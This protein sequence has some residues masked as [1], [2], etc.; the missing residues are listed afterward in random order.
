MANTV[1]VTAGTVFLV[2]LSW[3]ASGP[4]WSG[5]GGAWLDG[6]TANWNTVGGEIPQAPRHDGERF[7]GCEQVLRPATLPEDARVTAAG[8]TLT[9]DARVFGTTTVIMAMADIGGQCRPFDYQVFVFVHGAFA[10][11]LSPSPMQS[12]SDGSLFEFDVVR[13]GQIRASFN[14]YRPGDPQCC[15]SASKRLS[16]TIDLTAGSPLLVPQ[17]TVR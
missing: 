4:T 1:T 16:Y 14:R 8:W 10:G 13:E 11:T 6:T 15:A 12:R 17:F 3:A 2:A 9:G 5:E 7:T